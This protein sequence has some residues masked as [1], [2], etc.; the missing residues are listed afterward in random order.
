MTEGKPECPECGKIFGSEETLKEHA[1][2]EHG[3]KG[4]SMEQSE[5]VLPD[6]KNIRQYLNVSLGLGF[7]IG[8][9]L[10]SAVFSGYLYW[11]SLDH[12]TEVP[13][14]VVTCDDCE[15]DRF[16]DST[17]RMFRADYREVDYQSEEGQELIE[18][19]GLNYVPGFIFDSKVTEAEQYYKV[20]PTLVEVEDAY[21]IP[22]RGVEVAQRLSEGIELE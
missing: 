3:I 22:D 13:I 11:D 5:S 8:I 9:V 12:R 16:V 6:L 18:R 17:D 19:Y 2:R 15:Y 4:V 10:T 21:V 7:L 20:E 14:T 1:E